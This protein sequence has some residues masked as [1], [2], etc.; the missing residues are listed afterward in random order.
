MGRKSRKN[1]G[2]AKRAHTAAPRPASAPERQPPSAR[3]AQIGRLA[4]IGLGI[5]FVLA[6]TL[7]VADPWSFLG[8]LPAYGIPPVLRVPITVLM[9]TVEV[10]LGAMLLAGWRTRTA[11]LAAAGVLGAFSA[12]IAYGWSTGTLQDC[13]C[14]GPMLKRT[15]PEA[16]AQDAAFIGLAVL[17]LLW[18]PL[19]KLELTR[20]RLGTLA[21]V[22]V[23]SVAMIGG[24]LWADT[25]TLEERIAA[26][27]YAVGSD[28]PTLDS[29][30]LRNR[31]V[32]LY[33][34]HPECPHCIRNGPAMARIAA[35][36]GL[37]EVIGITHDVDP[38][39]VQGYLDHA[40]AQIKAY[41]FNI[42]SFV[43]I[44]GD[45][46]VPQLV[47]LRRGRR[48]RVWKGD[49]P[50]PAELRRFVGVSSD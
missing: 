45:G 11:S 2:T 33:L 32:F 42:A 29:L 1:K 8:S 36:P 34:F 5:V 21:T 7:K 12:V 27:E 17:G 3:Q 30:N 18:A 22:A 31:D 6:G 46:A 37:P 44:T 14:F 41:E 13:G 23:L 19:S 40:G 10:V 20:F 28:V 47:F 15:P 49:L 9:P 25:A 16:L 38:G 50:T 4:A 24:T 43:Q 48:E 39:Q 35:D 26:A